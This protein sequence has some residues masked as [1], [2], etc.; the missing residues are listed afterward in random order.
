MDGREGRREVK[1]EGWKEDRQE[2]GN[3][4]MEERCREGGEK[5]RRMETD[6]KMEGGGKTKVRRARGKR[7]SEGGREDERKGADGRMKVQTD[8][9][10]QGGWTEGKV[11]GLLQFP[12]P[13][14]CSILSCGRWSVFLGR[15]RMALP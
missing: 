9:W 3:G 5:D 4:R 7:G 15:H 8:G 10:R 2:D 6:A 12:P 1:T 11:R 13:G 14:P